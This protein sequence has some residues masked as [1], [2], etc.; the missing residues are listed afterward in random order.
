MLNSP[1]K[2]FLCQG[3][4]KTQISWFKLFQ[5]PTNRW[6]CLAFHTLWATT[7]MT[8]YGGLLNLKNLGKH[9]HFN[10]TVAGNKC[11]QEDNKQNIT[12]TAFQ[13]LIVTQLIKKSAVTSPL[14]AAVSQF[15]CSNVFILSSHLS[16]G[17]QLLFSRR[18]SI[19]ILYVFVFLLCFMSN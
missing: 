18:F 4:K 14:N 8:Y 1:D 19:K 16:L 13:L 11:H 10:T 2:T 3:R 15:M 5:K 7:V 6:K 17:S 9:L 12:T